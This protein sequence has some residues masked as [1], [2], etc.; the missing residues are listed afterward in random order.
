MVKVSINIPMINM[1]EYSFRRSPHKNVILHKS[2]QIFSIMQHG[3]LQTML[4]ILVRLKR[5]QV[6][7]L[8]SKNPLFDTA[9]EIGIKKIVEELKELSKKYGTFYEPD[10]LLLSM[11]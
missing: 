2:L 9:K 7:D 4:V 1:K 5:L 6:W 10:P 3:L 11:C 8:D